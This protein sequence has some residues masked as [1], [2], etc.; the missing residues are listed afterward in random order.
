[1]GLVLSCSRVGLILSTAMLYN[2]G[3]IG[4]GLGPLKGGTRPF[5]HCLHG[6]GIFGVGAKL[7]VGRAGALVLMG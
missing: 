4:A 2:P 6:H 5:L 3:N 1:M 7:L